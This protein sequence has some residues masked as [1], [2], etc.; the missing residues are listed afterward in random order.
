[1]L[2]EDSVEL[3]LGSRDGGGPVNIIFSTLATATCARVCRRNRIRSMAL[4]AVMT[5]F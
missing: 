4:V 1:M 2:S 3:V 5:G